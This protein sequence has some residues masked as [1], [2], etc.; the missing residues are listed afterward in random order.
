MYVRVRSVKGYDWMNRMKIEIIC[1]CVG[2]LRIGECLLIC[3]CLC[4]LDVC[5]EEIKGSEK[6]TSG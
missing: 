4:V 6:R 1:L 5:G 3:T 2:N